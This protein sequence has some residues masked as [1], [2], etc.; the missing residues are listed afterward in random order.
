MSTEEYLQN[1]FVVAVQALESALDIRKAGGSSHAI[2]AGA[3]GRHEDGEHLLVVGLRFFTP[4][5]LV[6]RAH[7]QR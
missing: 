1:I 3:V 2:A 6:E 4:L 5:L 7:T